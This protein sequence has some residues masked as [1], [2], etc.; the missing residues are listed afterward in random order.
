MAE[1]GDVILSA[2]GLF[3]GTG[4]YM[5]AKDQLASSQ[6]MRS[7]TTRPDVD[8][9]FETSAP[10]GRIVSF[11]ETAKPLVLRVIPEEELG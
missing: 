7:M 2:D 1:G 6:W 4:H 8:A 9:W 10:K 5:M 11:L 3:T